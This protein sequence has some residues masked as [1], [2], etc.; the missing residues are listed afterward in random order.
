ML[1]T[2]QR[3]MTL[4]EVLVASTLGVVVIM[5]LYSA[6]ITRF[7]IEEEL[8]KRATVGASVY[9]GL[10]AL[11]LAKHLEAAD[12]LKIVPGSG[13]YQVRIPL[14]AGAAD[15]LACV[16]DGTTYRWDQYRLNVASQVLEF[17]SN[18]GA[19]CAARIRLAERISA[20][21]LD[22]K[23]EA[24]LPPPGGE[25]P[26]QDNNVVK[27]A[28]TWDDGAGH[29]H[30]FGSEVT[31]RAIPYSNVGVTGDESGCGLLPCGTNDPPAPCT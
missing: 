18:T 3:G 24:T 6:D 30:I 31:S 25:P 8:R 15:P 11:H 10:A 5:A 19:G 27:Y 21:R 7:R 26:N 22:Y 1:K 4:T 13:T 20:L 28:L 9:A 2:A 23:D 29:T 14:C 12:R 17:F 16:N